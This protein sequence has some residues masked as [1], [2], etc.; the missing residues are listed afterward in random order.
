MTNE[1]VAAYRD[2]EQYQED[3]RFIR[4]QNLVLAANAV[5]RRKFGCLPWPD[6]VWGWYIPDEHLAHVTEL[7]GRLVRACGRPVRDEHRRGTP[8]AV[9]DNQLPKVIWP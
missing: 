8:V 5:W 9:G 3:L 4:W 1:F 2:S 6:I 7:A